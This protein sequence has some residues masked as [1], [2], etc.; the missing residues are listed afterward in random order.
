[1]FTNILSFRLANRDVT[2]CWE[3]NSRHNR[4]TSSKL[5]A[6]IPGIMEYTSRCNTDPRKYWSVPRCFMCIKSAP[7]ARMPTPSSLNK[8][9][10]SGNAAAQSL[11]SQIL[12]TQRAASFLQSVHGIVVVLHGQKAQG[13]RELYW[14]NFKIFPHQSRSP[15]ITHRAPKKPLANGFFAFFHSAEPF[16]YLLPQGSTSGQSPSQSQCRLQHRILQKVA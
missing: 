9:W 15:L 7:R 1:M 11:L 13:D 10:Q 14:G 6:A 5:A 16:L 12:R 8:G 4:Q 3:K 2:R